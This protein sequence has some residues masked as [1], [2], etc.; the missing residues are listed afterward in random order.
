[1][2]FVSDLQA[3]RLGTL[4]VSCRGRKGLLLKMDRLDRGQ[5]TSLVCLVLVPDPK[6]DFCD[7]WFV[8]R[9]ELPDIP[10]SSHVRR[11]FKPSFSAAFC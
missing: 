10:T 3:E 6:A 4:D 7:S 8:D 2:L 9:I 1:M 5:R 11:M